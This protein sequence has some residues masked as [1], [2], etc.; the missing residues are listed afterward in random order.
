LTVLG[1]LPH[2]LIILAKNIFLNSQ[3]CEILLS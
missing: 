1:I 2:P 3:N